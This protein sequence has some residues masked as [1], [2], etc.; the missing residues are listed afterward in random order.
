MPVTVPERKRSAEAPIEVGLASSPEGARKRRKLFARSGRGVFISKPGTC[1][2][3]GAEGQFRNQDEL[4]TSGW[5]I[6]GERGVCP[7]CREDGWEMPEGATLPYRAT[8]DA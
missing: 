1:A 2:V 4:D 6:S 5:A 7:S 8:R 3:C